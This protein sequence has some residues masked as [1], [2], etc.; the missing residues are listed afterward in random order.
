MKKNYLL[1]CVGGMMLQGCAYLDTLSRYYQSRGDEPVDPAL[2]N[3]C[4]IA[5]ECAL[6][7]GTFSLPVTALEHSRAVAAVSL[8]TERERIVDI[9]AYPAGAADTEG[10]TLYYG[11]YLPRGTYRFEL[12]AD[13]DG[14][15]KIAPSEWIGLSESP[16]TVDDTTFN[17]RN[18]VV[19]VN[20]AYIRHEEGHALPF[21]IDD[22]NRF[23]HE[24]PKRIKVQGDFVPVTLEDNPEFDRSKAVTGMYDPFRFW[25]QSRYL[26][27]LAEPKPGNIPLFFLHG[28]QGVPTDWSY[29]F[30]HLDLEGFNPYAIFYPSG[31]FL[32]RQSRILADLLFS[33]E[34]FGDGPK[35]LVA[36]SMG[37]LIA[38]DALNRSGADGAPLLYISLSA[39]YGGNSSAEKGM[40]RLPYAIPSWR[41]MAEGS[42]FIRRLFR[43]PPA[44]GTTV[45]LLFSYRNDKL[46][47][48]RTNS[49]GVIALKS[50]LRPE[51]QREAD[52]I[53][54]FDE[55]HVSILNS[56]VTAAYLNYTLQHF[57][58]NR[59]AYSPLETAED[60]GAVGAS[61]TEVAAKHRLE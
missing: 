27:P 53:F 52:T 21:G 59:R 36:H 54:G 6:I 19:S 32:S 24:T 23:L 31:D 12:Y 48:R 60:D 29:L 44:A 49:D 57:V 43:S 37:A 18:G 40:E 14:N 3:Q 13:L 22:L 56:P 28:A 1:L 11:F 55:T 17:R 51:A 47:N 7:Y 34:L 61:E 8:E 25:Q 38:R 10:E 30:S 2:E 41:E 45:S 46:L 35:V 58:K 42:D 16:V 33:K 50:Q 5:E 39:P 9:V 4:L 20:E 26:Y 15:H